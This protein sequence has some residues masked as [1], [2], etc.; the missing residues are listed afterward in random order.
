MSGFKT[1]LYTAL[2]FSIL[3]KQEI[4]M[5]NWVEINDINH[6]IKIYK[7]SVINDIGSKQRRIITR[8]KTI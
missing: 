2:R 4:N 5:A 8:S 7:P 3:L 6:Y 1:M